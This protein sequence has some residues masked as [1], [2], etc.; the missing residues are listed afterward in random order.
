[1]LGWIIQFLQLSG[2]T[3]RLTWQLQDLLAIREMIIYTSHNWEF[4]WVKIY[5]INH[6]MLGRMISR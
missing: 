6:S 3:A 4:K 2:S 5:N 1:M